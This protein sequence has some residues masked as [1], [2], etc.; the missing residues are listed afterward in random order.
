MGNVTLTGTLSLVCIG[1]QALEVAQ[2]AV[3]SAEP[4]SLDPS[5]LLEAYSS[6]LK[7]TRGIGSVPAREKNDDNPQDA[8]LATNGKRVNG[9]HHRD[10][11]PRDVNQSESQHLQR[12]I[13]Q[14]FVDSAVSVV[15]S[16]LCS[17]KVSVDN[18]LV[19]NEA[20]L[21]L[22]QLMTS[23]R[24]SA[25]AHLAV[26]A[27]DGRTVRF[28]QMLRALE[29]SSDEADGV[30]SAYTPFDFM[31]DM[32][33]FC[34]DT[35]EHQ[36]VAMIHFT[37]CRS[38]PNDVASYFVRENQAG[39]RHPYVAQSTRLLA[40][41][42]AANTSAK[43][44]QELQGLQSKLIVSGI[45]H[46][47]QCA[48]KYSK[49][50]SSLLCDALRSELTRNEIVFLTR[51]LA[52]VISGPFTFGNGSK[53]GSSS[54]AIRLVT[55]LCDGFRE[56][57]SQSD[58]KRIQQSVSTALSQTGMI[59]SLRTSLQEAADLADANKTIRSEVAHVASDRKDRGSLPSYQFERLVF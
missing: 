14:S 4:G 20:R 48:V 33:S 51:C 21:M 31:N 55:V 52:S 16:I 46:L 25:R 30:T 34:H 3:L 15:V 5:F 49:F 59:V 39:Q 37:M 24:V 9:F 40:I 45:V 2:T 10:D 44:R 53:V 11:A 28:P 36:M 56:Y 27:G 19:R 35:S 23:G 7:L 26:G 43:E 17:S 58:Q 38:Q 13:P 42:S 50:N 8:V 18:A 1:I 41:A 29:I 32:F 6:A 54:N 47:V 12:E 57:F 22:R